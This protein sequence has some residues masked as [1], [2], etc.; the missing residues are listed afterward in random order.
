MEEIAGSSDLEPPGWT[1]KSTKELHILRGLF[2]LLDYD[3]GGT[4]EV[5]EFC[6]GILK[7]SSAPPGAIELSSLVKQCAEILP[8][9][10]KESRTDIYDIY[11][12]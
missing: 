3:G 5:E 9:P 8:G 6:S 11:D 1:P 12:I 7:A 2:H 4:V 10:Q